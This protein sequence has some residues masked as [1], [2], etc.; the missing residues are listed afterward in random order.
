VI[1]GSSPGGQVCPA[2]G[3]A[4][5]LSSLTLAQTD[6]L[7]GGQT[8]A[9]VGKATFTEPLSGETM[10]G[11]FTAHASGTPGE[12]VITLTI[13]AGWDGKGKKLR[14]GN[15]DTPSGLRVKGLAPGSYVASWTVHDA[16]GDTR[17]VSTRFV[18]HRLGSHP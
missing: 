17:T 8:I 7:S 5:G 18:E 6:E 2:S 11:S 16:N 14:L 4:D 9:E 10:Y 12:P 1:V 13:A 3:H 15:V